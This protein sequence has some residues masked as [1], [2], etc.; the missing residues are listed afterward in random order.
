MVKTYIAPD[1]SDV[2][3]PSCGA[4]IKAPASPRSRRVQCPKCREVVVIETLPAPD[5]A[6]KERHA[7]APDTA[8]DHGQTESLEARVAALEAMVTAL[9]AATPVPERSNE[10]KKLMWATA[11]AADP[12]QAFVPERDKAL[13]NNLGTV[14]ARE[15]TIRIPAGNPA[16][17]DRAVRFREIFEQAGWTVHGPEDAAPNSTGA[18]LTLGVPDLPVGKEAAETYLALKAAGFEPIPVL[19]STLAS[20]METV[21]LSLTLPAEKNA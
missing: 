8:K 21:A 15:I 1:H 10:R 11:S 2:K 7:P 17:M 4:E 3:C 12:L 19:D 18:S 13:A 16:A 14:K 20:G 6:K 9:V 5:T